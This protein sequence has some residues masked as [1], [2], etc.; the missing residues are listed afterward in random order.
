M[1]FGDLG[2]DE[3]MFKLLNPRMDMSSSLRDTIFALRGI[4]QLGVQYIDLELS[5][6]S[7]M[8]SMKLIV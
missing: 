6:A 3:G 7:G 8:I 1:S 2:K 4:L 5:V